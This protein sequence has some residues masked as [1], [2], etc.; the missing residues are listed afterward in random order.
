MAA[1]A[2]A[3]V[4]QA[5]S[6]GE[7]KIF[8]PPTPDTAAVSAEGGRRLGL[9]REVSAAVLLDGRRHELTKRRL[10][11]GP[12]RDCDLTLDDPNVSRRHA[13]IRQDEGRLLGGRPRLDERDRG[14]R[15]ARVERA[16]LENGD[17]IVLGR[18]ASPS[19]G[20]V[21]PTGGAGSPS[22]WSRSSCCSSTSSSGGS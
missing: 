9:T 15:L 4:E 19:T 16:E 21:R 1:A 11:I 7:T 18:P 3:A 22:G 14:E 17:L 6:V 20:R 5:E 8:K 12:S 2:A 10:V 13:E